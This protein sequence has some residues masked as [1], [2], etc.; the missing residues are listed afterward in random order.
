MIRASNSP[1]DV[2]K[3]YPPGWT[4]AIGPAKATVITPSGVV[5]VSEVDTRSLAG[6]R[7]AVHRL[8]NELIVFY[9]VTDQLGVGDTPDL[10][11]LERCATAGTLVGAVL[12]CTWVAVDP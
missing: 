12:H 11:K 6:W 5:L 8:K 1:F 2:C 7:E 4:A 3:S 9:A 10:T